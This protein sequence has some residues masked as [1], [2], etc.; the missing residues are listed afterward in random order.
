MA[1][2]IELSVIM[3]SAQ[4]VRLKTDYRDQVVLGPRGTRRRARRLRS[5]GRRPRNRGPEIDIYPPGRPGSQGS[6]TSTS[7]NQLTVRSQ[8]AASS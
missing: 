1:G 2:A 6:R 4:R 5:P 3:H 7:C 8:S